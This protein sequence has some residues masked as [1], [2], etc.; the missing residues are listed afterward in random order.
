MSKRDGKMT[1]DAISQ[2]KNTKIGTMP[3]GR[4][5]YDMNGERV[6]FRIADYISDPMVMAISAYDADTGEP[7]C[8]MSVNFGNFYGDPYSGSF[9][10]NNCTFIDTNNVYFAED[11]LNNVGAKP[12][13]KMGGEVRMQSGFCT[14]PLYEFPESLLEEMDKKGYEEHKERYNEALPKAQRDLMSS[15]FGNMFED[16]DEFDD[17]EF[18]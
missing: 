11:F 2:N 7:Y 17:N 12:Y 6:S 13:T 15:S 18:K 16:E 4:G 10:R 3:D 5:I 8:T 1:D 9:I 14:Y